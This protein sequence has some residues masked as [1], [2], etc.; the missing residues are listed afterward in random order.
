VATRA[1]IGAGCPPELAGSFLDA[2]VAQGRVVV[3]GPG[4]RAP[5]HAV[6]LAPAQAR[7][8][9]VLL[10]ALSQTPFSPPSLSQAAAAS[11]ASAALVKE[12]ESAGDIVRLAADLAVLPG[13]LEL[14]VERLYEAAV[15]EGPLTASRAKEILGTTRRYALPL[16]EELDRRGRTRRLGDVRDVLG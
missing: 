9:E 7:A 6:R 8:R 2:L 10:A 1:A 12:L 13:T 15:A 4:V 5:H 3:E 16:L 11:G 14:A